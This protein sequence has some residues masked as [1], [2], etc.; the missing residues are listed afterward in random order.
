LRAER[1]ARLVQAELRV[2]EEAKRAATTT[3]T[4]FDM[5][6]WK[7]QDNAQSEAWQRERAQQ[8]YREQERTSVRVDGEARTEANPGSTILNGLVAAATAA[9]GFLSSKMRRGPSTP[10]VTATPSPP[11]H[12]FV[13]TTPE[14]TSRPPTPIVT[15][16]PTSSGTP[17]AET[18]AARSGFPP[19]GYPDPRTT[20]PL[21][22]LGSEVPFEI[23][24]WRIGRLLEFGDVYSGGGE[25]SSDSPIEGG[26]SMGA[27][28]G[29]SPTVAQYFRTSVGPLEF[30][31]QRTINWPEISVTWRSDPLVGTVPESGTSVS[32]T[33]S[34]SIRG[35]G[36][37]FGRTTTIRYNYLEY[38]VAP[39]SD[40]GPLPSEK[41]TAGSFLRYNN[42]LPAVATLVVGAFVVT[43]YLTWGQVLN[44]LQQPGQI[45]VPVP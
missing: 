2:A 6:K 26:G 27:T 12:G 41:A 20:I 8:T 9:A 18:Q 16:T 35:S 43:A 23:P 7:Q 31:I 33:N 17:T 45:L 3:E 22:S 4:T 11:V 44:G 14:T 40:I 5:A 29:S 24:R 36:S 15:T 30:S 38:R 25:L 28:S 39:N 42:L 34:V 21:F 1:E 37:W 10:S 19:G 13:P 32:F